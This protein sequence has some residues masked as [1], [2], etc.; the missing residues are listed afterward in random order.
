MNTLIIVGRIDKINDDKIDI[1]VARNY[2]NEE[3]I[4]EKDIIPCLLKNFMKDN[5]NE[6][7]KEGDLIGVKGRLEKRDSLIVIAEKVTF[8][9]CKKDNE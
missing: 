1:A 3:G 2:K 6:Y 4:Y 7:C 8:L 9:S 5:I